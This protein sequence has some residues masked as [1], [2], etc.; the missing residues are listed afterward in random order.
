[1]AQEFVEGSPASLHLDLNKNVPTVTLEP[2]NIRQLET[3]DAGKGRNGEIERTGIVR[4]LNIGLYNAGVW[5]EL[6]NGDRIWRLVIHADEAK[7][8]TLLF[9]DFHM[10]KGAKLFVYNPDYTQILGAY[11]SINNHDSKQFTTE[12][13]FGD[14]CVLEYYEPA[15]RAFEGSFTLEGIVHVYKDI[16]WDIEIQDFGDAESCQIN[17][18]CSEGN[19]WQ[20]VKKGVARM[21]VLFPNPNG[22]GTAQG[23][24]TGSL[25]NN[26]NQDCAPYF[27]TAFHCIEGATTS[28]FNNFIFYFNYEAS[29]CSNPS[30]QSSVTSNGTYFTVNGCSVISSSNNGGSSS[31]DFA[32]LDLNSNIPAAHANDVY[33]NGWDRSLINTVSTNGVGI[34]HPAGDIKKISTYTSNLTTSGWNGNG[35][36]S[37]YRVVWASTTNGQ[38]S[39][40]GGSSGSPIFNDQGLIIGTLTGGSSCCVSNG[41]GQFG[42]GPNSPDY[43]GKVSYHWNSNGTANNRRLDIHLDPAGNGSATSMNGAAQ[44]CATTTGLDASV[45][46]IVEPST[47]I[48]GV[49]FTPEVTLRNVGTSNL[50]TCQIIYQ[51]TGGAQQTFNWSGNLSSNATIN[52]TLPAMT[53]S[54]GNNTFTAASNSPNGSVDQ[55]TANDSKSVSFQA[56]S[57][58]PLPITQGFQ[59]GTFPPTNYQISNA[60]NDVTWEVSTSVGFNSSASMFMDNWDYNG[61]GAYDWFVLPSI[62]LS[63]VSN[64]TLTYDYAYAYYDGTQGVFYDSLAVAYSIDC[65]N[66]WFALTFE[67]GVQLATAGGESTEFTPT[68]SQWSSETVDLNITALQGQDNVLIAFVAVNGYGNNL[69]VDNINIQGGSTTVPPVADF[70]S[71]GTSICA[72]NIVSFTNTST[73][74]PTSYTWSFPGGNPSS[75]TQANPVVTYSNPGSYDVTLTATNAGGSNTETKSNYIA[76]AAGPSLS[77]SSTPATCNGINDGTATVVASGGA[78]TYTYSWTGSSSTSASLSNLAPG[79]YMATVTDAAGCS[80][81]SSVTVPANV[82]ID[83]QLSVVDSSATGGNSSITSTVSGGSTPYTYTWNIGATSQNLTGIGIG[84]YTLTVIDVNGCSNSAS[85]AV[86]GVGIKEPNWLNYISLFPNPTYGQVQIDIS[87]SSKQDVQLEIFNTLGQVI[88]QVAL[89]DFKSGIE[90][91]DVR[92]AAEG[93]YFVRIS[94]KHASKIVRFIKKN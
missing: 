1:M 7:A 57:G 5:T 41:C 89:E 13:V 48:C 56:I 63:S 2:L 53:A 62:D 20:D 54:P 88:Y 16:P 91:V 65:G 9:K 55:N 58:G 40:E 77:M 38:G 82:T 4:P 19:A 76:V 61:V 24:C 15:K 87:L 51:V 23:W 68:S 27:L 83:V 21:L 70:T 14:K 73:Q 46:A 85:A 31:S 10:P 43:Y 33:Y 34:H 26:T 36:P 75:S 32:L 25:V 94:D 11:T 81:S 71:T 6:E 67:G 69:Y 8:T 60:D 84:N 50:T 90:T 66:S 35:L 72:G 64:P 22:P 18:N 39:T 52:I 47:D 45:S 12:L 59:G 92:E 37:H 17:V 30:S 93:V 78:G 3:E 80:S 79:S 44:P 28:H 29:G 49:S 86:G 42:S 74:S